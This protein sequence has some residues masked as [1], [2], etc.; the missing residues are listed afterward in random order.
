MKEASSNRIRV[1]DFT[2]IKYKNG[3]TWQGW[4]GGQ[5]LLTSHFFFLFFFSFGRTMWLA[6]TLVPQPG[7]EPGPWQ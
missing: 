7:T 1:Y 6:G 2:Y 3:D 5:A 4:G